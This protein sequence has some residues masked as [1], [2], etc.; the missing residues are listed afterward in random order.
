MKPT[1]DLDRVVHEPARLAI[2]MNLYVV[3]EADAPYLLAQTG[4]TWGNLA[5]HLRRL[6]EAA[7]VQVEKGFAGRKPQTLLRI[8]E[9]GRAALE[10]YRQGMLELLSPK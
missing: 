3:E 7:Y 2:L 4:L 6:E 8:T 9:A 10:D 1:P 5:S